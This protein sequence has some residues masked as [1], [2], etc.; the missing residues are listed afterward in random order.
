LPFRSGQGKWQVSQNG[1]ATPIWGRDGKSLYYANLS[2][3][4]FAVPVNSKN[5][6][7]EFGTPEQLASNLSSQQFFYDV[8]PDG[9]KLLLNTISEQVN[10]SIAVVTNWS[11]ELKK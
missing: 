9:K 7:L 6:T 1:G 5:D 10:Q 2:F 4:V 11:S 3:A 8:A